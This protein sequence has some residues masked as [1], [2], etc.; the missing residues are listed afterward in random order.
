MMLEVFFFFQILAIFVY[1]CI[2]VGAC[3][4]VYMSVFAHH[5]GFD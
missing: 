2:D 3:G 1:P 5:K 4:S